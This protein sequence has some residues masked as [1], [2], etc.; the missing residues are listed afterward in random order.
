MGPG[1][2]LPSAGVTRRATLTAAVALTGAVAGCV[3]DES[4]EPPERADTRVDGEWTHPDADPAK[5]RTVGTAALT[6]EPGLQWSYETETVLGG[7]PTVADSLVYLGR[8]DSGEFLTVEAATGTEYRS[9]AEDR[10]TV[11]EGLTVVDGSTYVQDLD[12]GPDGRSLVKVD[13][14]TFE[15]EWRADL[16]GEGLLGVTALDERLYVSSGGSDG[17]YLQAFDLDGTEQWH[18]ET[19]HLS[20]AVAASEPVVAVASGP[21]LRCLDAE[22]GDRAWHRDL[23][24]EDG[25]RVAL[26]DEAVIAAGGSTLR[27]VSFD[28]EDL[29]RRTRD[30]GTT[31]TSLAA[32]ERRVYL[33]TDTGVVAVGTESGTVAWR[34]ELDG[35][36]CVLAAGPDCVYAAAGT[37]LTALDASSGEDVW[38]AQL[39]ASVHSGP[40][41]LPGLV[42]VGVLDTDGEP[43]V[44]VYGFRE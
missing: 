20:G 16:R 5:T 22:T 34:A 43:G 39:D 13:A 9:H 42:L 3:G 25:A 7:E 1:R 8:S 27:A 17:N 2:P 30:S 38:R 23:E 15:R 31:V 11:L 37:E 18:V 26:V 21:T 28:G 14:E 44:T 35:S 10:F 24:T 6:E 29:W 19:L 36:E 40:V 32:D 12:A 33:G 4:A 41:A